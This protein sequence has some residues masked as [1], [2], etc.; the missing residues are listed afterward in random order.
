MSKALEP[1]QHQFEN[2][3]FAMKI[4][5]ELH[6]LDMSQP[7][8]KAFVDQMAINNAFRDA[9]IHNLRNLMHKPIV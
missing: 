4:Q 6:K 3:K 5:A 7:N 2:A 8:I 1:T 9:E